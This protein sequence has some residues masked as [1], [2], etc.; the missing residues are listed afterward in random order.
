MSREIKFRS[1]DKE[2]GFLYSDEVGLS[3]FFD[4]CECSKSIEQ[5]TGL[6]DKNGVEIYGGDI[7]VDP[8]F[9]NKQ[10]EIFYQDGAIGYKALGDFYSVNILAQEYLLKTIEVIGNI[11]EG[12][13]D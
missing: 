10:H 11:H 3:E 9:P 4:I 13:N 12:C 6:R 5:Y 7:I 2:E 8:D 1:W